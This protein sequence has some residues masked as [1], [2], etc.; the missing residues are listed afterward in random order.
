MAF[1]APE[2]LFLGGEGGRD[3]GGG[4]KRAKQAT[5]DNGDP[6]ASL[7]P[8]KRASIKVLSGAESAQAAAEAADVYSFAVL[9]WC[10]WEGLGVALHGLVPVLGS[11]RTNN[12]I[13]VSCAN[14]L[15]LCSISICVINLCLVDIVRTFCRGF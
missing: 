6:A 2:H 10:M 14:T 5:T 7:A 4:H 9:L 12:R 8:P 15:I 13:Q 3:D 11:V 1:A